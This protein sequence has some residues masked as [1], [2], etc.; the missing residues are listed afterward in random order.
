MRLRHSLV[1]LLLLGCSAPTS[2]T[3]GATQASATNET[4][5]ARSESAPSPVL[6]LVESVPVGAIT[7]DPTIANTDATWRTLFREAKRSIAVAEF[8][9][10]EKPKDVPGDDRLQPVIAELAAAVKRG[11]AVRF[12]VDAS[13]ARKYPD[14]LDHLLAEGIPVRK[15]DAGRSMGGVLHAKF[16]VVDEAKS[17]L[18]SANFDWRSLDHIHELGVLVGSSRTAASLLSVFDQDWA[19]AGNEPSPKAPALD[20][21]PETLGDASVTTVLSPGGHIPDARVWDLDHI[22]RALD[23]AKREIRVQLLSYETIGHDGG[24]FD[25]LDAALRRAAI[26]GVRVHLLLSNWQKSPKKFAAAKSLAEVPGIDVS[27]V[28]VPEAASGF[29]PFARVVHAK[30]LVVDERLSWVGTSNWSGDYFLKS[31][32]VGLVV[33]SEAFA[34]KLV[35]IFDGLTQGPLAERLDPSKTYEPPRIAP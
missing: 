19:A 4:T 21:S 6:E 13:F 27:F 35:A 16:V 2:K 23:D 1:A 15:L 18:G 30:Y 3:P 17:Y 26:R 29:I 34:R 28:N 25:T 20:P 8:Y 7:D 11:V 10:S 31:R 14:S 12:L 9:V 5:P 22:V 24:R 33:E 32:N